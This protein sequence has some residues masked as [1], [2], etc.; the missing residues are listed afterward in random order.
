L[1]EEAQ[2]P[3]GTTSRVISFLEEEALLTRDERKQIINVDWSSLI[4]RWVRDYNLMTSNKVLS[5]LEPRTLPALLE[6]LRKFGRNN[7]Y[8]VTGS[9]PGPS[10]APARLAMIYV[11][12]IEDAAK[13]LDLISYRKRGECLVA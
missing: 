5:Y 12:N 13:E 11:D 7:R 3:L 4:T 2:I 8:A 9:I 1:A 10:I 6:K